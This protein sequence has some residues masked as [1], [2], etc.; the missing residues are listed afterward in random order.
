VGDADLSLV[1]PLAQPREKRVQVAVD[2]GRE[3]GV[4]G[5]RRGALELSDLGQRLHGGADEDAV[6][7]FL[8]QDL[9]GS[10]LVLRVHERVQV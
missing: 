4:R 7:E 3:V 1:A 5:D 6:A 10:G 8:L 2:D 9:A